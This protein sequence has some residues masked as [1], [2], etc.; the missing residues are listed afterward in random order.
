MSQKKIAVATS[1]M[2]AKG[3][4]RKLMNQGGFFLTER[5]LQEVS[6]FLAPRAGQ[7][8]RRGVLRPEIVL[9]GPAVI[10]DLD[11]EEEEKKE[12]SAEISFLWSA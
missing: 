2:H 12:R 9:V 6:C 3:G 7:Q 8:Q 5:R 10:V 1:D 4:R 11:K